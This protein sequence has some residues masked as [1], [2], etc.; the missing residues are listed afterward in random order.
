M[1]LDA[2]F[3]MENPGIYFHLFYG[4]ECNKDGLIKMPNK[5]VS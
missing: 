2:N 1:I 5:I 4:M 3:F